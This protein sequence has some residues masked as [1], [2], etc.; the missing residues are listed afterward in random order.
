M[1][2]QST[3]NWFGR[4]SIYGLL[5]LLSILFV[6]PLY[7]LITNSLQLVG[8]S[9]SFWPGGLH[10]ENYRYAVTLIDYWG[11]TKSS[12]II[13]GIAVIVPTLT[14][15][16]VGFGFARL[17]GPGKGVLFMLMLSTM[18]LPGIVTQ[19]PTYVI[20]FKIGFINTYW[21]WFFW[22]LGGS[23]FSI[24]LYRQF[25]ASFPKELEE[26][27]RIDG[28]STFRIFWNIFLPI[29]LPVVAT[30]SILAFN[31]SWGGD[32]LTPFMFLHDDKYPLATALFSVGYS[33]PGDQRIEMTQVLNAG[34]VIFVLP[35][36]VVF[37]IGQRYLVEGVVSS[38]V[39]G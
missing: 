36:I 9:S 5:V 34:L 35:I 6:L 12:I 19:I 16:L 31:G 2:G 22:A 10:F 27:A 8:S 14:S 4:T 13:S 39:K 30:V 18:M 17:S 1:V 37:F 24:F 3:G 21:P 7:W 11:F 29:S 38:A 25:F 26:A 32:Y 28:C 15:A 33:F 20:F 23:A